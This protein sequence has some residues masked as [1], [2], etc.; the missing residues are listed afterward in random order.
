MAGRHKALCA[1]LWSK[2]NGKCALKRTSLK[3]ATLVDRLHQ[4]FE[5]PIQK[6][7]RPLHPYDIGISMPEFPLAT[8]NR[9]IQK[10]GRARVSNSA[11][12][13]LSSVL[14]TYG[15]DL[16]KEAIKLAEH[17]GAKTVTGVDVR[18]AVSVL[19]TK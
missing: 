10:V 13:E 18:A 17:R 12:M 8:M 14:E 4:A 19:R 7:N 16:A 5:F 2:A 9:I 15:M 6:Q 11:A 1:T 3:L